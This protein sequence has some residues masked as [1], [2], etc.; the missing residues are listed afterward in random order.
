MPGFFYASNRVAGFR[1]FG[2]VVQQIGS[3]KF[4]GL[5]FALTCGA[6]WSQT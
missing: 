5:V 6:V 4:N 3:V 1:T 2:L